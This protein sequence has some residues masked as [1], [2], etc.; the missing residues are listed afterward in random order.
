MKCLGSPGALIRLL[1][2]GKAG[3]PTYSIILVPAS[4]TALLL[5]IEKQHICMAWVS[6]RKGH[7]IRKP[8]CIPTDLWAGTPL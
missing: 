1:L 4:A 5:Q 6:A 7:T 3:A 2:Q 8:L